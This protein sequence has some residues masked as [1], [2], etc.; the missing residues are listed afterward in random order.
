MKK[1]LFEDWKEKEPPIDHSSAASLML[2]EI[3]K[4]KD[5][6]KIVLS[7]IMY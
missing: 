7:P 3:H 5:N 2:S 6:S 4:D 1:R